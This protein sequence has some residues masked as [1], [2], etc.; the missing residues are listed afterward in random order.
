MDKLRV[1]G[2]SLAECISGDP[3]V[4]SIARLIREFGISDL[5]DRDAQV[6]R[7][8]LGFVQLRLPLLSNGGL[9]RIHYW[10]AGALYSEEPHSHSWAL[11]SVV[12]QGRMLNKCFDV[13]LRESAT[14]EIFEVRR[15]NN[16]TT[17]HRTGTH[18]D[19]MV[20]T[21]MHI[22]VGKCY[23]IALGDFHTSEPG[24][25]GALTV[26]ATDPPSSRLPLVVTTPQ[27]LRAGFAGFPRPQPRDL[28]GFAEALESLS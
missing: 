24:G 25:D 23:D 6:H 2:A 19:A 11:R 5:L 16:G 1:L 14:T 20:D 12:L 10:P 8:I 22:E 13:R 18:A 15:T 21:V 3:D 7:H 17:R 4:N 9:V 27:S 26:I 28:K